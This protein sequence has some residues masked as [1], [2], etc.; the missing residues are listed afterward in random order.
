MDTILVVHTMTAVAC[1][2]SIHIFAIAFQVMLIECYAATTQIIIS[3]GI[4]IG[5]QKSEHG[6]FDFG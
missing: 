4:Q 6:Y 5:I 2:F 3:L 1:V